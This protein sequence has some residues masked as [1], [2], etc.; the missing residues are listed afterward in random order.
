MISG[1][2][3]VAAALT[4]SDHLALASLAFLLI[5]HKG[6]YFLNSRVVGGRMETPTWAILLGL[7]AGE[8]LMG[9]TGVILAP[10]LIHYALAELKAI[11]AD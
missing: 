3:I 8:A 4:R 11:P 6:G 9:V 5:A 10:S 7:L 1:T 2:L